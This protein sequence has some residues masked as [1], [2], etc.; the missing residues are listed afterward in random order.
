MNN[1]IISGRLTRNPEVK[2]GTYKVAKFTV[3]VERRRGNGDADYIPCT[4]FSATAEFVQKWIKRGTKINLRGRLQQSSYTD[5]SGNTRSVLEVI[6]EDI[7]FAESKKASQDDE[8]GEELLQQAV[9]RI[10][11]KQEAEKAAPAEKAQGFTPIEETEE[12]ENP[13]DDTEEDSPFSTRATWIK[14]EPKGKEN[15]DEFSLPFD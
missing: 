10:K 4:A 3:A 13:F 2:E 8:E 7:E 12:N 6:A 5:R 14:E 15:D 11:K 9:E 1:V